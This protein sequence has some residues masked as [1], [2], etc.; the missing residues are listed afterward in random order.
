ML[1]FFLSNKCKRITMKFVTLL[2]GGIM[3]RKILL[4]TLAS[5]FLF[6]LYASAQTADEIIKKNIDA[7]GGLGK[8]KSI[9]TIRLTGLFS[10]FSTC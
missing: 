1:E 3:R 2:Q 9:K 5:G 6:S 7:K 4:F 8:F 10:M